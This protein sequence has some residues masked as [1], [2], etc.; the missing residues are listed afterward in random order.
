MSTRRGFFGSIFG[1]IAAAI[2]PRPV[3]AAPS[4]DD[5]YKHYAEGFN[6]SMSVV[7]FKGFE[8]VADPDPICFVVENGQLKRDYPDKEPA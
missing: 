5:L 6:V 3:P 8:F 4:L 7:D 1:G 2:C